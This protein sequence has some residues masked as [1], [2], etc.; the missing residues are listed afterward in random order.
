MALARPQPVR[1]LQVGDEFLGGDLNDR[2]VAFDRYYC[3]A[4]NSLIDP[5]FP[6]SLLGGYSQTT[7]CGTLA[8]PQVLFISYSNPEVNYSPKYSTCSA[9]ISNSRS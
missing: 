4:L 2:L 9:N 3:R 7:D 1:N 6:D 5:K 8:L